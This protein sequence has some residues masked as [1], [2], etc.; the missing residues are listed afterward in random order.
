MV[1]RII[2]YTGELTYEEFLVDRKTQD[3][4]LRNLQVLREAVK[5]LSAPLKQARPH[6]PWKEM[7]GMRNKMVHDYFGINYDIVGALAKEELPALLPSLTCLHP[8]GEQI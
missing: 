5:R 1:Q 4:V 3:A 2:S 6:L 8:E 7:A